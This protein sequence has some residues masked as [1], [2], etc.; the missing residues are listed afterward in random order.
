MPIALP[1]RLAASLLIGIMTV[2]LARGQGKATRID[3][4][5]TLHRELKRE[6]RRSGDPAVLRSLTAAGLDLAIGD[7]ENCALYFDKPLTGTVLEEFAASG[8]LI[9]TDS[10]VGPV[11]GSHT[12]GFYLA[13]V[14]YRAL[15]ALE[16]DARVVR[17]VSTERA[18]RPQN[19]RGRQL[20]NVGAVHQGLGVTRR[21]GAGVRIAIADSG[22]DVDHA[23]FPVPV[24]VFDVTDGINAAAWGDDVSNAVT[25][26][27]THVAGSVLGRGTRSAGRYAGT[28]KGADLYFYKIGSD[29]DGTAATT[30]MIKAINRALASRCD[31]FT[32]SYGGFGDPYLDGSDPVCQ[33]IDAAVAGGMTVFVS[34]GNAAND[35]AHASLLLPP[36]TTSPVFTY[37]VDNT[38]QPF[39]YI[40]NEWIRVI[41]RDGQPA[42]ANMTLACTNLGPGES[43]SV[44]A[45][46]NSPRGTEG[47]LYLL[48]SL[49]AAGA[50]RTYSLRL[51]NGAAAGQTPRVHCYQNGG[52]G[53]LVGPDPTYTNTPRGFAFGGRAVGAWTQANSWV[54]Y[55]GDEAW[56]A[57]E[58]T[59]TLASF[60]SRGPRIDGRPKPEILAPG[61]VVV[62]C[63]D[64]DVVLRDSQIVDD[65]GVRLDGSG[66]ADYLANWGTSMA[67]PLAAGVAALLVEADPE[68]TPARILAALAAAGDHAA[69]PDNNV[70][71]G[72]IDARKALAALEPP[73]ID[74]RPARLDFEDRAIH[75]GASDPL[76]L[77]INNTGNGDL[78]LS[79]I[80]LA[81]PDAAHFSFV[82]Q[83]QPGTLEWLSGRIMEVRFD[84][85]SKG[86]KSAW[87]EI[88]SDDADEAE[89]TIP[90]TGRGHTA[91]RLRVERLGGDPL[92]S[93][94]TLFSVGSALEGAPAPVGRFVIRNTGSAPLLTANIE[95][96]APFAFVDGIAG[97][98]EPGASDTVSVTLPTSTPGTFHATL[99]FNS[100][101]FDGL[102][103]E[104]FLVGAVDAGPVPYPEPEWT[105][106]T[107]NDISWDDIAGAADYVVECSDSAKFAT[108]RESVTLPVPHGY[109]IFTGLTGG[110]RYYYR[111]KARDLKGRSSSWSQT[112]SSTQDAISPTGAIS[113]T[114]GSHFTKSTGIL[115]L[116]SCTDA[117]SGPYLARYR[118]AGGAWTAWD[119]VGTKTPL[120][121]PPGDGSKTIQAQLL[122]AAGNLSLTTPTTQITLDQTPPAAIVVSPVRL[123][124][125]PLIPL[126]WGAS[127]GAGASGVR[128]VT[129]RFRKDDGP[130]QRIGSFAPTV[131]SLDFDT[132]LHGGDGTYHFHA[133][134]TDVAGNIQPYAGIQA[135]VSIVTAGS[136]AGSWLLYE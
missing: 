11:A 72:L 74:V 94:E 101:D 78:H 104:L 103:F 61:A 57:E 8:I 14:D 22:L 89:V 73:E 13:R 69:N 64:R 31:I 85:S 43:L 125:Q 9:D 5:I 120:T 55:E 15:P 86:D 122:D 95:L 136:G 79:R 96:P 34:A 26:H 37:T 65:D 82:T 106:G 66:P 102:F 115:V 25:G 81:G 77:V 118:A 108:V 24:E 32:M 62:S 128:N 3:E 28:A 17:A 45:T 131:T 23:D 117:H 30:D 135:T 60:S 92:L 19:E 129:L 18:A 6:A 133:I 67:T 76:T 1:G 10:W 4:E 132:L 29:A 90:L 124:D 105:A 12:H 114:T 87:V 39:N 130:D 113:I 41:W 52:G 56:L 110:T 53:T 16:L 21:T 93:G 134:A 112:V 20:M 99:S 100:N 27:G 38:G 59:A 83:P 49:V 58:T 75:A 97:M 7:A 2:A 111:V 116:A 68:A 80:A 119:A 36:N 123:L 88:E 51:A 54:N 127:D 84:P 63:R 126:S 71:A 44:S 35:G 47:R 33:A 50:T 70:G 98:I 91:P 40:G 48:R 46:G 109:H 42:D 107:S 121:L